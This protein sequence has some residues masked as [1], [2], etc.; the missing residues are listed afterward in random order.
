MGSWPAGTYHQL[1]S[2]AEEQRD[3]STAGQSFIKGLA[4]FDR[5]ND[6]HNAQ[7]CARSFLAVYQQA[8]ETIQ[9][10]LKAL[11]EQAGFGAL[12]TEEI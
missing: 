3:F 8:D 1:G 11:W 12:P 4:R 10:R 9:A 5:Q 6:A 2:I 7:M